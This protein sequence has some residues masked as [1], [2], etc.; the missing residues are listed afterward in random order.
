MT[1][2]PSSVGARPRAG[3][4]RPSSEGDAGFSLL[5]LLVVLAILTLVCAFA[6]PSFNRPSDKLQL[7]ASGRALVDALRVTRSAAVARNTDFVMTVDVEQRAF[8]S[9]VVTPRSLAPQ[10]AMRLKVAE[11]ERTGPGRGGF[12]FFPDGSSTGGDVVL[13]SG[14]NE[15]KIC[16]DW[17]TGIARQAANC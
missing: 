11:P 6:L 4:G 10:I 1:P 13:S 17:L 3:G 12:R 15:L 2:Y 14:G 5:E 9:S 7:D 16:V 8:A